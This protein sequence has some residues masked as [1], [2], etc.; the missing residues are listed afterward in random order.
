MGFPE[1]HGRE[2][3]ALRTGIILPRG[4]LKARS[5][6]GGEKKGMTFYAWLPDY[7]EWALLT[8]ITVSHE[9]WKIKTVK[10]KKDEDWTYYEQ[11]TPGVPKNV[12]DE[13]GVTLE[14]YAAYYRKIAEHIDSANT[15]SSAG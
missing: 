8:I 13:T 9:Q 15:T 7:G 4:P 3:L 1:K 10:S 11:N 5:W 12:K 14:E 2:M 6:I